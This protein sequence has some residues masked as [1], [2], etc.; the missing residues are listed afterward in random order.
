MATQTMGAL[1]R[2]KVLSELPNG[3]MVKNGS[4]YP[5]TQGDQLVDKWKLALIFSIGGLE[6]VLDATFEREKVATLR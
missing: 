4:S 2:E 1:C 3:S 5:G 6:E